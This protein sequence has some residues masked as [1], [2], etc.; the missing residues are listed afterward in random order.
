MQPAPECLQ[1][2]PVV[3]CGLAALEML[4]G[5]A[6]DCLL[7]E[8]IA[9]GP[10]CAHHGSSFGLSG[11]TLSEVSMRSGQLHL[12]VGG[13]SDIVRSTAASAPTF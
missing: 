11:N 9:L 12:R 5:H 8:L 7:P 6:L 2:N 4:L 13:C 3:A 1:V 10:A